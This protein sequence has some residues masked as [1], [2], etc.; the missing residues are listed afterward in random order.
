MKEIL[1]VAVCALAGPKMVWELPRSSC[2]QGFAEQ[3]LYRCVCF[4]EVNKD[5]P[6]AAS[7]DTVAN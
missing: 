4:C 7:A 5:A 2:E 1:R 6:L 3:W